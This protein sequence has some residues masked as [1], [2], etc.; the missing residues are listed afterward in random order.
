MVSRLGRR[1]VTAIVAVMVI[2]LGACGTIPTS[3]PGSRPSQASD[4]GRHTGERPGGERPRPPARPPSSTPPSSTPSSSQPPT[5]PST[6]PSS[7]RS[8]GEVASRRDDGLVVTPA[9]VVQRCLVDPQHRDCPRTPT[10]YL[11]IDDGPSS[12]STA[13]YLSMLTA[14]QVAATF[15]VTGHQAAG[16]PHLLRQIIDQGST[17]GV[18]SWSHD[19]D[20]L[21]PDRVADPAQIGSEVDRTLAALRDALGPAFTTTTAF[22]YPGGHMSWQGM[23][24]ADH[25][26]AKRGMSWVDWNALYGDAEPQERRPTTRKAMVKM[27]ITTAKAADNPTVVVLLHDGPTRGLS[28]AATPR[29]I[30][31]FLEHGYR[32]GVID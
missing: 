28:R 30:D 29:V 25:A 20:L 31:W 16:Q 8:E 22:R 18:H 15:F 4:S 14:H 24:P 9:A 5:T 19:Y 26:L 2:G 32:F 3:G 11:T 21:Y 6:S 10:V 1:V 7:Q 13:D 23:G 17:I 12:A 27:A